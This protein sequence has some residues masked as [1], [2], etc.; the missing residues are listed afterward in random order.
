MPKS[1]RKRKGRN[2]KNPS[3]KKDKMKQMKAIQRMILGK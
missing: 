2:K 3:F 1:K